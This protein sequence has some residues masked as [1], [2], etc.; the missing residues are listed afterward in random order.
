MFKIVLISYLINTP[1]CLLRVA[2]HMI[3][4]RITRIKFLTRIY[5]CGRVT[6]LIDNELNHEVNDVLHE[7][8]V[9]LF[10]D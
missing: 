3:V 7:F 2:I 4:I 9:I 5:E 8:D 10:I 6:H 1:V